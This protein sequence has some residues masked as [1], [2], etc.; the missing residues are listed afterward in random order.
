MHGETGLSAGDILMPGAIHLAGGL[1]RIEFFSGATVLL[2][3]DAE[4]EIVSA[5]AAKFGKGKIRV[6]V[7]PPAEGFRISTPGMELIDIGTEFAVNLDDNGAAEVH[8]F[9]GEVEAYPEGKPMTL[10]TEGKSLG[11]DGVSIGPARPA[12]FVNASQLDEMANSKSRDRF[13]EWKTF[14]EDLRNDRR[15]IAYY[16]FEEAGSWSRIVENLSAPD[17]KLR[18]GAAVGAKRTQGRWPSKDALEF[19]GPGDRVRLDLGNENY[20]AITMAAWVRV[21]GLDRKYNALLLTDDYDAGEPH[22]QIYEDGSLMFSVTYPDGKGGNRNQIYHSPSVFNLSNQRNWHHIAVTYDCGSGLVT[23]FL[24]G[25]EISREKSP[26]HSGGR[27]VTF[28]TS[29]IGNWGL[30]SKGHLFPIRNLNGRIDEFAIFGE[31]LSPSEI[32]ELHAAGNPQ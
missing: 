23:Q 16:T 9:E 10:L 29:E 2:E 25:R 15:L 6:S 12:D 32:Q 13:Q 19:K 3:G 4:L 27:T 7:P 17:G 21:D 22:W 8:V 31:V 11:A 28:G 20:D 1:A 26:F 30:P 14:S 5:W 24:D 18:S